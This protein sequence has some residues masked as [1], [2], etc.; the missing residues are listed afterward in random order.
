LGRG[1]T[2]RLYRGIEGVQAE[3][4]FIQKIRGYSR[5]GRYS[6]SMYK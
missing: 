4:G 1:C 6:T 3:Q 2:A 5:E